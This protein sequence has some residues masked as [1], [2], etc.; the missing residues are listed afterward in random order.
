MSDAQPFTMSAA[1]FA[2]ST[3][4]SIQVTRDD[5]VTAYRW[6]DEM[7]TTPIDFDVAAKVIR[8]SEWAYGFFAPHGSC[9][10][11]ANIPHAPL[12]TKLLRTPEDA[13][14][15]RDVVMAYAHD[16]ER[17]NDHCEKARASADRVID[18][19]KNRLT[20]AMIAKGEW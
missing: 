17:I 4:V 3:V 14:T 16:I 5:V 12:I 19:L 11:A 20:D 2:T 13:V 8:E 10:N 18:R 9:P 7:K 15:I 1:D 6:G